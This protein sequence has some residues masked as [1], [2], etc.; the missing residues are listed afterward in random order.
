M[1]SLTVRRSPSRWT[2]LRKVVVAF[3]ALASIGVV[4]VGPAFADEDDWNGGRRGWREHREWREHEWREREWRES[5][6]YVYVAPGYDSGYYYA[7]PPPV[8][9]P[10]PVP[11][12]INFVFPIR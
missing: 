8:Y 7:P 5:H 4:T 2:A 10:P 6:P 1:K 12:S 3:A 11:P 9:V